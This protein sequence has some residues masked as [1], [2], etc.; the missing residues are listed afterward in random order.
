MFPILDTQ[1][2]SSLWQALTNPIHFRRQGLLTGGTVLFLAASSLPV[3]AQT[4]LF[5]ERFANPTVANPTTLNYGI[6]GNSN[7]PCLTAATPI[8]APPN[9][10]AGAG[11]PA[12]AT[13]A[14]GS[15]TLPDPAG[16]GALRLTS[17]QG[18]QAA[19]VLFNQSI[20]SGQGLVITFDFFSYGGTGADGLSFVLQDGAASS[21]AAGAFGGSLGYSPSTVNNLPGLA[22]GYVGIGFDEF[23]N[24]SNPADQGKGGGGPGQIS[25]SVA[26]RGPAAGG[27]QYLT[28]T[29]NG[30][31]PALPQSVD[32]PGAITRAVAQRTARI[33]L[34]PSNQISV[35]IDFGAG[36]VNVI[37]PFTLT[38]PPPTLNFGF[39]AS[40]GGS[41]NVHEIRNLSI[42][43][44]APN[45][46]VTKVGP[47]NGLTVGVE[48]SYTINVANARSAGPTPDPATT[49]NAI[50]ATDTL[51]AGLT[52]V[53]ATGTNWTCSAVGQVVTCNY[54][55]AALQPG[56]SAPPITINVLPTGAVG[57]S[58]TNRAKVATPG[59]DPDNPPLPPN[60]DFTVDNTTS[61]T[62]PVA[63]AVLLTAAKRGVLTDANGNGSA[64]PGEIITYTIN[65]GNNGNISSTN[66]IFLD[67]IPNGTT[68]VPGTT[69]LNNVAIP[70]VA[71][72][73][74]P[75]SGSG[76]QVNSLNAPP[77][78][79]SVGGTATVEFQVR[80][81]A[82]PNVTRI[83]NQGSVSSDQ[84]TIPLPT[85]DPTVPGGTDPTVIPLGRLESRLRLVKRVTQVNTTTY[86]S[87]V[88]NPT[89]VND[90]PGIWPGSLQPVGI[91]G[92]D[93][94]TPLKS[95]DEV[96]YTVYFL[97]D[98]SQTATNVRIC[99]AI[100]AGTTFIPNSFG[101]G[102]GLLL[103]Q[104][105]TQT[106][107][108]N[109]SDT[110][111][112]AFVSPLS[113]V[114]AP[115]PNLNNPTG[116]VIFPLG[117][118]PSS[119]PNNVGFVRF[120]VKID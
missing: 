11:I 109:V 68:Y 60:Q 48:G 117:D 54:S 110:D 62:I 49:P 32:I 10:G 18:D 108:T 56:A 17:A 77:G 9:T 47:A 118:I 30:I 15:A 20:P 13:G 40:T 26:I 95:G 101:S 82:S 25:D 79:V 57:T 61:I 67:Q 66:T 74:M 29:G 51:P 59:D 69:R 42:T 85:D 71:N 3:S 91:P 52:F 5:N 84:V 23:G 12:C 93:A 83:E 37:P 65:I 73:T 14:A 35:D 99:D 100:P 70:D 58:A 41:T 16:S 98:G 53:S 36:F 1:G 19:F 96:E 22:G 113:A 76:A 63:P 75:F 78:E 87:V 116:A 115:C 31:V 8:A 86:T 64:D 28:G 81:N 6:S 44:V 33:T 107:I 119:A 105:G 7:P 114:T 89:D 27:Y 90:N 97:S 72:N 88:D 55:G 80:I 106:P 102:I 43:T 21:N 111:L 46:N 2:V 120:R 92:L 39:A 50:T 112:G 103:N 24:F 4:V 94:Q 45:L 38:A 34:T 104:G